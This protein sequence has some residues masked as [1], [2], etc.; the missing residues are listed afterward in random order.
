MITWKKLFSWLT[1]QTENFHFRRSA[2]LI[3]HFSL[4][5]VTH[6]WQILHI[7]QT[8]TTLEISFI[9]V[10]NKKKKMPTMQIHERER[11]RESTESVFQRF[12]AV[13]RIFCS[14]NV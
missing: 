14:L 10:N 1:N 11:A 2:A 5:W 8:T 6:N 12:H 7:Q 13:Q 3:S 4:S 9:P